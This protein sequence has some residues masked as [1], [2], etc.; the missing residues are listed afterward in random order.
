MVCSGH[1]HCAPVGQYANRT[2]VVELREV[3]GDSFF[4]PSVCQC[5]SDWE[6]GFGYN[7]R[8]LPEYFGSDCAQRMV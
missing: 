2:G 6:V 5:F 1:G 7:Q 4:I 3:S 8:Q